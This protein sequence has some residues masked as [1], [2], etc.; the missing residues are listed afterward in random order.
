MSCPYY[1][2]FTINLDGTATVWCDHS[3]GYCS[4]ESAAQ[5][6]TSICCGKYKTD[7][8]TY[9]WVEQNNKEDVPMNTNDIVEVNDYTDITPHTEAVKLH[10]EII[11]NGTIAAQALYELCRCLKRMKDEALYKELG[12]EDFDTYC[13]EKA[14]IK[15]RQAQNYIRTYEQLGSGFL[16]SNASLGITKL[17]MLT[18]V[19]ALDRA[20]FVAENDIA[21]M[22]VSKLKARIEELERE[23]GSRCEQISMLEHEIKASEEE[24]GTEIEALKSQIEELKKAAKD[25]VSPEELKEREREIK[26]KEAKDRK[27]AIKQA[28]EK[29]SATAAAEFEN[30]KKEYQNKLEGYKK[31]LAEKEAKISESNRKS[32]EL[33][34]RLMALQVASEGAEEFRIYFEVLNDIVEKLFEAF[35]CIESESQRDEYAEKLIALADSIRE[36]AEV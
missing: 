22:S 5:R 25:M 4:D 20:D 29:A 13:E 33:E 26:L 6:M 30:E 36:G 23:N 28:Y 3:K 34:D 31:M 18:H 7:C 35:D 21:D 14:N 32:I 11:T 17:E 2:G 8:L 16:Q 9:R 1:H 24:S 12:Y 15:K 10:N 27:E 19:P